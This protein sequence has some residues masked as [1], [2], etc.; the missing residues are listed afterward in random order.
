MVLENSIR[1]VARLAVSTD[2]ESQWSAA[3]ASASVTAG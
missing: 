1:Q 3:A 2:L